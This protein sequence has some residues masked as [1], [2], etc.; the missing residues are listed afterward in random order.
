MGMGGGGAGHAVRRS[1]ALGHRGIAR[2]LVAVDA[3]HVFGSNTSA[4]HLCPPSS[5]PSLACPQLVNRLWNLIDGDPSFAI[6]LLSNAVSP[7]QGLADA[8]I[9]SHGTHAKGAA[10]GATSCCGCCGG[11]CSAARHTD[12]AS[13][14]EGQRDRQARLLP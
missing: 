13:Q 12:G 8:L 2:R 14:R 6:G 5:P 7:L 1:A 11:R 9:W 3:A 10:A 4:Y